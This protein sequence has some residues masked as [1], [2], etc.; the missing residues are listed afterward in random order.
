MDLTFWR[1][2]AIFLVALLLIGLTVALC[3]FLVFFASATRRAEKDVGH[4][5]KEL[6]QK[7]RAAES[8]TK[9]AISP[10]A[11]PFVT[12]L[13]LQEGAKEFIRRLLRPG[14]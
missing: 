1:D 7:A 9:R 8:L 14:A 5:L 4:R 12:L 13:A 10:I 2:L 3:I 11:Y 6:S